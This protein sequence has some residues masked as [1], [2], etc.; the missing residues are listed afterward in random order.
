MLRRLSVRDIVLIDALDLEFGGG[1]G[2]MT[3]ETGAGKSILLDALGAAL[4]ARTNADLVRTGSERGVAT[5][6]FDLSEGHPARAWLAEQGYDEG[7]D[8][9]VL[10]RVIGADGRSRA[11]LNDQP[12]SVGALKA[13]GSMLI[14]IH[15]QFDDRSLTNPAAHGPL[16][17]AFGGLE[18]KVAA[19][20]KRHAAWRAAERALAET[21]AQVEE[22]RRDADYVRHA[23]EELE[24]LAPEA[25][26]EAALDTERRSM[27]RAV[28][29]AED[30]GKAADAL[31][32][33]GAEAMLA[34]A[35]R[36][37]DVAA[38][39]AEGALDASL[40][41]LDQAMQAVSDALAEID[42]AAEAMSFDPAQLE[43]VEERLF[44][45][46]GLARKH[47]MGVEE[48]AALRS[49][50]SGRLTLIEKG[51]AR[52]MELQE[53]AKAAH[54]AYLDAA[55]A[56]SVARSKAGASLDRAVTAELPPLKLERA[57][58]RTLVQ[59]DEEAGG[60]EGIDRVS[61]EVATN[62]GSAPGP[63]DR[64]AS[65]GELSRFLL[66]MKVCLAGRG[67]SKTLIFDEIDRGVGGATAAAIGARLRRLGEG[68][69][70]L[71]I[72]HAPQ[73][74]AEASR[75]WR[76]DKAV[77]RKAGREVTTTRVQ[78]LTD[79]ERVDEL[80]RMLAGETV[81]EAA[82]EAARTLLEG[83]PAPVPKPKRAKGA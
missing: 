35:L 48:L 15:G 11:F 57:R 40:A 75:Q 12:A 29:I 63:I 13:L 16:L 4:G 64:V 47:R 45:L 68:G 3:G 31:G 72:T 17:D 38:P 37:L 46:R 52:L 66:A 24:Q 69:Q 25:G 41:S 10:R 70:A 59:P 32:P 39:K 21:R 60:A 58:F 22:A 54:A 51:E 6:A 65:G 82:R 80:A 55:R 50:M 8:E 81:T 34:D 5:A 49:T 71:V 42:R 30:V 62:P 7:E 74:A 76:I 78:R 27:Q 2:A 33:K 67:E 77:S 28:S 53:E 79:E 18:G 43:R 14:E 56:L 19:V 61:F 73:V 20:R 1:L 36:R 23:V 44:A 26:E 83:D 9:L